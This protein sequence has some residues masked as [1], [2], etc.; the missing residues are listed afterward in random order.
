MDRREFL[1]T[2]LTALAASRSWSVSGAPSQG[3][4]QG[5]NNKI[6]VAI[7]GTGSRGN[8][9]MQSW[10]KHDDSAFVAI[11]DVAKDRL[12][13]TA[14]KLAS[15]GHKADT[16]E[17]Y[18]RILERKDVD[19]V[20]IATPDH[21]HSPMTVDACA[22][23]KDVYCEKPV[24]NQI[25]PA[26][27]MV[28]AARQYNRVVQIGLQQ[29]SWPHFQEGAKL[30]QEGA[31][32]VP[33]HAV[34]APPGGGGFGGQQQQTPPQPTDPPPTLNW[35]MFQGP[36]ARKPFVQQRLGWRG[37]YDYGGGNITDWGVH[38]VD[39]MNW[40][41]RMDEKTPLLV[42]AAA[43]YVR[44]PRNPERVP[45]TYVVTMQ[46]DNLI[47]TLS[48]AAIFG[49]N[50][51]QWWGNYFFGDRALMLVNRE[52]YEVRPRVPP[53]GRG[54]GRGGAAGAAGGPPPAP[55]QPLAKAVKV[56][57]TGGGG[58]M[59]PS[60]VD[61]TSAHVRNFLDCIRSRQKPV[62]DIA[63]GFNSTLPTLMAI[64]SIKAGGKAMK[65]DASA[66]RASE[67]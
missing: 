6:R 29:R 1:G 2:A 16:Y 39:V 56:G 25:E 7:I 41:L 4:V 51:E 21:W 15:A 20:L 59:D 13:N 63:I 58:D 28:D 3:G 64:E 27:K 42:Q 33:N 49:P 61:A 10:L 11:C 8:Q 67:V 47:A 60:M 17:D 62:A 45:D 5:A 65:W 9:V 50:N 52:G 30:I 22:A 36:A 24:S 46:Y 48:N 54:G 34:M 32:G 66:R 35:E 38:I 14:S 18:R 12:D 55:P 57:F 31:I 40:Y 23:G 19:A 53:A 43:Q 37:W 26:L 44:T